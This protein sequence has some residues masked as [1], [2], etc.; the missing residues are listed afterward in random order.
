MRKSTGR[1]KYCCEVRIVTAWFRR[2]LLLPPLLGAFH[3]S[4]SVA[5]LHRYDHILI[6]V[7]ENRTETQIIGDRVNAPYINSLADGGVRLGNMFALTHPSQ[8][9]Y[10]HLFSGENQGVLDDGL[11]PSFSTTPTATYPF[12]TANMAAELIAA[13]FTFAG[14]SEQ[15]EAAGTND[16]ADYDPH[17]ATEPGVHYRRKHSPWVNWVAKVLPLPSNQLT[18]TVNRAFVDFP[19]NFAQ[20][21]TVSF[22]IPNQDHDMHDGSRK[23]GDDWLRD[24]LDGYAQWART[25]NS[26]LIVTW[27]E[28]D[29]NSVNQI[30]TIFYGAGLRNGTVVGG[31]WTLHNL[32]RTIEDMY[33]TATHAGAAAQVRS[34]VGAFTSDPLVSTITFRQ[35]LNGY[36]NAQDTQV[37]A[38]TP[39][40]NNAATELL[41]VDLDTGAAAGNQEAQ[42][43]VRFNS[44][45]GSGAGQVPT[46]ATIHSAKL[47]LFTPLSPTGL[48]YDSDDT[49]RAHRMLVDW[50]DTATWNSVI[51]GVNTDDV[52]AATTATFSLVP[53]VDGA[54][55]IFD[56]TSDIEMFRTGTTNR[57]WVL[58]PSSS[59]TGNG[60]SFLS[61]ETVT[62]QLRPT[63]EIVYSN[64][65]SP[66]L[67]W[68]T[69]K[70][71]TSTNNAPDA[72]PDLDGTPN[73]AE[74]AYNL[75][76]LIADARTMTPAGTNGLPLARLPSGVLQVQFPRRKGPTAAGLTYT[77]QFSDSVLGPWTA[78]QA[79]TVISI[80]SEW[81][82]VLVR[83][84]LIGHP[85]RF[86]KV[87]L[88]LQP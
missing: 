65:N 73:A 79:P 76:P 15:L 74:F 41:T 9:N 55:A 3:G 14:F 13:G 87:V 38:E 33:G 45:F 48:D 4:D 46:N 58:R 84:I 30:P 18:S 17:S 67:E 22:V 52:E 62:N 68:A 25:N 78:G 47:I 11:P 34:I 70:N 19:T 57:G 12:K 88:T 81:D 7:E 61:S 51:G 54:P 53:E 36:T 77:V 5:A 49:F 72:D 59:G 26:L 20:L 75:N 10:I 35:G 1:K 21:P 71:L 16:W 32:L 64:T 42:T 86:G 82:R 56:V 8:P 39:G 23:Q 80:N 29:Y 60:W 83:D 40:A 2:F 31:T 27:D 66:Y 43:L 44:I 63:L 37:G 69:A 24:N 85:Q 50:N 6:V 28:D